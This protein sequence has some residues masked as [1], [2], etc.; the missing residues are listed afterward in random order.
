MNRETREPRTRCRLPC[1]IR[2]GRGRAHAR[3]LDISSGGLCFIA[4]V[5]FRQSARV[6]VEIV[7]PRRG[8]VAVEG[9]V[10]H[11]R[12]FRQPSSGRRGWATGLALATP[13]PEYLALTSS[14]A[15]ADS[16]DGEPVVV[17][18]ERA[19]RTSELD[20]P[21]EN[22]Q[23]LYRVR[24]KAVD[25][26]RTRTLTLRAVSEAAVCEAVLRDL[27]G[28]WVVLGVEVDPID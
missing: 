22:A 14:G 18:L 8:V 11:R 19:S 12:P 1:T 7:V 21:V 27:P 3:V 28:D 17:P 15:L 26:A 6:H 4:P 16:S 13:G 23:S 20:A 24:L 9:E 5:C 2:V 10:R 25:S